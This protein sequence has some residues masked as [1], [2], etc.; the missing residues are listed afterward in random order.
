M[1]AGHSPEHESLSQKQNREIEDILS[2]TQDVAQQIDEIS[3]VRGWFRPEEDSKFYPLIQDYLG[4]KLDLAALSAKLFPPMD[5]AISANR[6]GDIDL[7]DLWYSV[8]HS[9]KRIS[10]RDT[11]SQSK[12]VAFMEAFKNHSDPPS[13]SKEPFY[14][15]LPAFNM[16]SREAYNNSPGAGAGFFDPEIQAWANYNYFLACLT[17]DGIDDIY[18]YAIWAMREALENVQKDEDV[19]ERMK[20]ATACQKYDA[21]V[22]A[23]AVW[24][25]ALGTKLYEKEQDLTPTNRN[26]GNPARGGELWTGRA[27]FSKER[28]GLWK[29]RFQ[30]ISGMEE[31]KK[32]TRDVAREAVEAMEKAEGE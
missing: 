15:V 4:G 21:Y 17:K 30:E 26:Q 18:L 20:P 5:E 24:V 9:S 8:I 19:D 10:Y 2:S 16:A 13:Q 27:E 14:A 7:M 23:A 28:W 29:R 3:K 22:P 25:F 31:L 32:E 6:S 1:A 11:E 12:I